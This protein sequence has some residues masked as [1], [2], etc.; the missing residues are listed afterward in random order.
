MQDVEKLQAELEALRAERFEVMQVFV[1]PTTA[2]IAGFMNFTFLL[3][4][5]RPASVSI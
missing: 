2:T 4:L 3:H 5:C 1:D